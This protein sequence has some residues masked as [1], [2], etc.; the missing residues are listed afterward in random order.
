MNLDDFDDDP[1][2]PLHTSAERA[3]AGT[4]STWAH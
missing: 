4:R 1:E 2:D 3:T